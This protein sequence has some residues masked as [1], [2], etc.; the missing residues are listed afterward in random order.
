MM[1]SSRVTVEDL[2]PVRKRLQVEIPADAVQTALDKTF[3]RVSQRARLPGFRPGKAPRHVLERAFGDDVRREVMGQLVEESFH[4]AVNARGLS[5][6]GSPDIDV[7][8]LQ[9][10]TPFRYSAT[11]EVWPTIALGDLSG[12]EAARPAVAVNDEDV[13]RVLDRM[14]ES[15]AQLRPI[16]DRVVIEAGDVV[17]VDLSSRLD[18]GEPVRREGVLLEAGGGSFPLALERQLV[19][20]HRGT[21]LA[22]RVPYP[23]DY[24]N[25]GLAGKTAEFDVE[26]KDIQAKELPTLDDDFARD[27]GRSGSLAELQARVRSDLERDAAARADEVVRE[28]IVDQLIAR[29][30]FDVPPSLIERRT[31]ALLSTL[32]LELP[33]GPDRTRTL[34]V[35][36]DQLRPRAERQVRAELLLDAVVTRDGISVP[37]DEVEAEIADAAAREKRVVEQVRA[38]YERPE[39]RAALRA[40]LARDRALAG[41]V[42]A[43]RVMPSAG[44]ESV[45]HEK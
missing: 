44:A 3:Q 2:S 35:I 16:E 31:E 28:V 24:G 42:A 4:D 30:P 26:V 10:G 17:R 12:L 32:H 8:Q 19:G 22:L 9:P 5:I 45:A 23:A 29:H 41:L 40:K 15:V 36:R 33:E 14:R 18:G 13:E 6:V 27:H 25:A 34:S 20:Q 1:D 37:D 39:A 11:V 38:F 7:D 43:A 21:H